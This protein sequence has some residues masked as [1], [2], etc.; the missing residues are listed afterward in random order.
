MLE[1]S[2]D[3]AKNVV[4][5]K[6][7]S[8]LWVVAMANLPILAGVLTIFL[9]LFVLFTSFLILS[10]SINNQDTIGMYQLAPG[11]SAK[12][13]KEVLRWEPLVTKYA[14]QYGVES[15]VGILLALIQQESS[16]TELDVMQSSESIGLPPNAITD[17]EYSIQ[18]GVEHFAEVFKKSRRRY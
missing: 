2:V 9:L 14:Q 16:G 10:G 7:K 5:K 11:G 12:V 3:M 4:K 13:S 8:W 6:V 15:Y 1:T 17:P 18:V